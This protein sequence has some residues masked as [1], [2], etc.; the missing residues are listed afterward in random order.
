MADKKTTPK[1]DT[2]HGDIKFREVRMED[3]TVIKYNASIPHSTITV[4]V[5]MRN[6]IPDYVVSRIIYDALFSDLSDLRNRPSN[7][8]GADDKSYW[9]TLDKIIM[10]RDS[11]KQ[12]GNV[13]SD[14]QESSKE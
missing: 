13:P 9:T 7:V 14:A 4:P 8:V 2:P 11:L 6:K 3:G 1:G 10:I 5:K 12:A